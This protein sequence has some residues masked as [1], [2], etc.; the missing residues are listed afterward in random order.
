MSLNLPIPNHR[1]KPKHDLNAQR[2]R[3]IDTVQQHN[4]IWI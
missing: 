4:Y 3:F 2:E 1:R